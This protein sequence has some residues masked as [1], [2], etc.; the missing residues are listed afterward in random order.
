MSILHP[1]SVKHYFI[2]LCQTDK[3]Q[4]NNVNYFLLEVTY[5]YYNIIELQLLVISV[6]NLQG[7]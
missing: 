2:Y 4:C 1:K 7:K 5:S 3:R 6:L